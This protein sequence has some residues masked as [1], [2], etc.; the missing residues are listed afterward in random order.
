[1]DR[2]LLSSSYGPLPLDKVSA[3]ALLPVHTLEPTA[4]ANYRIEDEVYYYYDNSSELTL[5]TYYV[6]QDKGHN[7]VRV[8]RLSTYSLA[9]QFVMPEE[10][11]G[12]NVTITWAK[13]QAG[14]TSCNV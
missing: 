4:K 6:M 10:T 5:H 2:F 1:M 9:G 14:S 13:N 11:T 12:Q 7:V 3:L 8:A